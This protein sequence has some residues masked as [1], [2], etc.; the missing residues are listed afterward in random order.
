MQTARLIV[1]EKRGG[2]A[3]ALR[4]ETDCRV[5]ETRS[6]AA[7]WR[8]LAHWPH[9]FLVLELTLDNAEELIRRLPDLG[10]EFPGAVAV[11]VTE[12]RVGALQW[13]LRESGAAHVAASPRCLRPVAQMARRHL[14]TAPELDLPT[15]QRILASLP[16]PDAVSS[17][18]NR[19]FPDMITSDDRE[20]I[21]LF[22]TKG[23]V[24]HG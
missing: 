14:A 3:A 8:E 2:W 19:P 18:R 12:R 16:W 22:V 13:L 9:S 21:S 11:I 23:R 5:Y 1:S 17:G 4:R 24:Q 7:C 20:K 15:T 10:R 6:L